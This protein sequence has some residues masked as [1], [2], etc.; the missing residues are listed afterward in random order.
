MGIREQEIDGVVL[1]PPREEQIQPR[2]LDYGSR[3]LP[4]FTFRIER[5]D[6]SIVTANY[7]GELDGQITQGDYLVMRG[8]FRG[9]NVFRC[10]R[11]WLRGRVDSS[12]NTVPVDPPVRIADKT[13]CAVATCIYGSHSPETH[14]LRVYRDETLFHK[15]YGELALKYYYKLS[16]WFTIMVLEEHSFIRSLIK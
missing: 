11:I 13:V 1:L 10:T 2:Q 12:G 6:G 15:R 8:F 16:P 3:S 7:I 9:P 5:P 14:F 4:S